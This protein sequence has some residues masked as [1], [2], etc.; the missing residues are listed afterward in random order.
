MKAEADLQSDEMGNRSMFCERPISRENSLLKSRGGDLEKSSSQSLSC[1]HWASQI[2]EQI[3]SR[4]RFRLV[5][6]CANDCDAAAAA[7]DNSAVD[8]SVEDEEACPGRVHMTGS[9][10]MRMRAPTSREADST[11]TSRRTVGNR[12]RI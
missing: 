2:C 5:S 9:E 3:C 6:V 8:D 1:S 11:T 12:E 4:S 7:A 10:Q